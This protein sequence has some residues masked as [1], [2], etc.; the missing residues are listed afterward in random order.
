[1]RAI[2]FEAIPVEASHGSQCSASAI[3]ISHKVSV[4]A[5]LSIFLLI[6]SWLFLQAGLIVVLMEDPMGMVGS[7]FTINFVLPMVVYA[8]YVPA[9]SSSSAAA[10]SP[11]TICEHEAIQEIT[12]ACDSIEF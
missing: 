10:K 6:S 11:E 8:C 3:S 2:A 7:L 1:M 5:F 4:T 9:S 12:I